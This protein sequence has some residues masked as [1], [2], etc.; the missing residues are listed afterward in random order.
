MSRLCVEPRETLK[1]KLDGVFHTINMGLCGYEPE[2]EGDFNDL[3]AKS[4]QY[5]DDNEEEE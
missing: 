3:S 2:I 5:Y 4:I 1:E